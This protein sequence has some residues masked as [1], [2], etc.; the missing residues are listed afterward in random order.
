MPELEVCV[1]INCPV[2]EG[3]SAG[4]KLRAAEGFADW[5]H[6][7]IADGVFTF[8]KSWGDPDL[9]RQL[10]PS[11]NI[12]LEVHLM[13]E[14]PEL[15]VPA[16]IEAGAKRIIVHYEA[17]PKRGK[18]VEA[19]R[20]AA[21]ADIIE[22]AH[23]AGVQVMLALNPETTL[24]VA[25]PHL[26]HFGHFQVFSQ[27]H[28]G[29]SGQAFLKSVLPKI[30]ALRAQ[31]PNAT[32]EVDGG[33]NLESAKLAVRAGANVLVSGSYILEGENPGARYHELKSIA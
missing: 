18:N 7:D 25:S 6:L 13:V 24:E 21:F 1:V 3:E 8:G 15:A 9:W 23:H 14:H 12:K 19:L 16:W 10:D 2:H 22:R 28:P 31:F 4:K 30:S 33:I 32:I 11:E 26:A 29:P 27:A 20:R 5:I 17:F